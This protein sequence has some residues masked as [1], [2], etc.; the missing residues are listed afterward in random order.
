[1]QHNVSAF[2]HACTNFGL[3]INLEKTVVM[4]QPAPGTNHI[5]PN[6]KVNGHRLSLVDKFT[7]LGST[8]S[9]TATIDDEVNA[10]ISKASAAF[11]RL[12]KNVWDKWNK[13]AN[14]A[15]S[16]QS[17]CIIHTAICL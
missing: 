15:E 8:V 16:L 14:K 6:I 11:G 10:R 13:P 12:Y 1:M 3:N 7:Y 2:A 4:Y 17:S 5:V 9:Q